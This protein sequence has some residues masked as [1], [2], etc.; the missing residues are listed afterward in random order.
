MFDHRRLTFMEVPLYKIIFFSLFMEFFLLWVFLF[1]LRNLPS[2]VYKIKT[3]LIL[4]PNQ[5]YWV[6]AIAMWTK[7]HFIRYKAGKQ[8]YFHIH[9]YISKEI[10]WQIVLLY[11]CDIVFGCMYIFMIFNMIMLPYHTLFVIM[12]DLLKI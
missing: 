9:T 6:S 11:E 8:A 5:N 1:F 3:Y 12:Y 2:L 10:Y 4:W 7:P